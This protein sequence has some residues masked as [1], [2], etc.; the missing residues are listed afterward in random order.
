MKSLAAAFAALSLAAMG[1]VPTAAQ[2]AT[3]SKSPVDVTSD[4]L[5]TSNNQCIS[6]WQGNVEALQDAARLRTDQL[7]IFMQ[8][9]ASKPGSSDT[10]CGDVVRME[11]HGAVYYMNPNERVH[12]DQAIYEA[13]P[14]TLTVT[15]DVVAVNGQNVLRGE[16]MVINMKTGQGQMVTGVKGRNQPGRVRGVFY[17]QQSQNSSAGGTPNTPAA[18]GQKR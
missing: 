17:P 18:A 5:D 11:A 6:T 3:N 4:E 9:K 8:T 10:S 12:G 2:I 1:A 15:G 13:E 14:D 7:K 16:R